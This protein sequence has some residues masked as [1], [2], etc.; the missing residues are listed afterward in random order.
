MTPVLEWDSL[1]FQNMLKYAKLQGTPVITP[2]EG[3]E[4]ELG[5]AI[6]TILHC[7]PEAW[8]PNDMS[9][10]LRIDYGETSVLFTGD[11]ETMSEYMMVDSELPLDADVLKVG[12]HGSNS[13]SS[14]EF[15]NAVSPK[16]A[17]ISCGFDNS[18]GHPHQEILDRLKDIGVTLFRTDMQGMIT[19]HSDGV[20]ITFETERTT[21]QDLF[22]API[23]ATPEPIDPDVTYVLNLHSCKFHYPYCSSVIDINPNNREYFYGTREEA[24]ELG[25]TPCGVCKP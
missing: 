22:A 21:K 10:V 2:Y 9:I 23:K 14:L 11:A 1:A 7:W 25:Y 4:Y 12:H 16:Y 13:S 6:I 18:Y 5:N 3:D 8:T 20:T 19:L 24:I 15:L 17:V